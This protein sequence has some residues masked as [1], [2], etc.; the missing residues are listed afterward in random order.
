M[1]C[2]EMRKKEDLIS[3]IITNEVLFFPYAQNIVS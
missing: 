2:I 3:D 1:K